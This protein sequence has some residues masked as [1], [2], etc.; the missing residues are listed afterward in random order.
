VGGHFLN[1]TEVMTR[2]RQASHRLSAARNGEGA[3]LSIVVVASGSS[4]ARYRAAQALIQTSSSYSAQVIVV[5]PGEPDHALQSL[6]N[7]GG[8]EYVSAPSGCSRAEMCDLG[9]GQVTGSIV[10][11]RDDSEVGDGAW[12]GAFRRLIPDA[13]SSRDRAIAVGETVVMDSMVPSA[14]PV[15]LPPSLV[16]ADLPR[17]TVSIEMAATM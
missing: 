7:R 14:A 6:L 17:P 3:T 4:D 5:S 12:L 2:A 9:M 13:G 10:A 1:P 8:A 11:V 16:P 15:D